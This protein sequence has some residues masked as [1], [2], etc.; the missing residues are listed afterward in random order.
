MAIDS[1]RRSLGVLLSLF[2]TVLIVGGS[3]G[4][5]NAADG[6]RYWNYFHLKNHTWSFA[7]T[8]P[9]GATPRDGAVEGYR[10][11]TSATAD[12]IPP[13][14]DL[15]KVD[16]DTVCS[17][18]KVSTGKKRVAVLIDY[19]TTVDSEGA[20]PPSPRAACAVVDSSANGQQVIESV[21]Q[22]RSQ[23]GLTCALDGYP[24][25]GCGTPVPNAKTKPEQSVAF[26]MPK[27]GAQAASQQ[28]RGNDFLWPLVGVAVVV[29][30]VG[31]GGLALNRRHKS[32]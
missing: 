3:A 2:L 4:S 14:A 16:F 32:A 30:L 25:K 5:A 19:G 12:G 8:G 7:Q 28:D 15:D 6:Y 10:F 17:D 9:A 1:R 11:G 20:K 27:S 18:A 22:V 13:R 23:K 21:A 24:A 26:D 29:V 31:G